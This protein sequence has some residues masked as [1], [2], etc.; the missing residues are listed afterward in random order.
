MSADRALVSPLGRYP[1]LR[2]VGDLVFLSGVSA[3]GADGRVIGAVVS[4]GKVISSDVQKQ[5]KVVLERVMDALESVGLGLADCVDVSVYLTN[6]GD[7]DT[8]NR[9]Y[10]SYFEQSRA[11]ARTT[12]GVASLPALGAVIEMK[13][14]AKR[15][16]P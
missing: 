11:P 2:L 8:F 10:A 3:R 13:V 9:V 6:M 7:Y 5:T 14:V 12:I 16:V 1:P 15:G 4:G